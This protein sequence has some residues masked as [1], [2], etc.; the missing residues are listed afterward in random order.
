MQVVLDDQIEDLDLLTARTRAWDLDLRLTQR[1]GFAGRIRQLALPELL[2][3]YARF[4]SKLH[5]SGAT[6]P[7]FRTFGVP[8][9]GCRGF[10]WL[11]YRVD[12][13]CLMRFDADS[14]LACVSDVDFAVYTIS[15]RSDYLDKLAAAFHVPP[16]ATDRGMARIPATQMIEL[17]A[18]ATSATF[19]PSDQLRAT[20][21]HQLAQR[22]MTFCAAGEPVSRPNPRSR[23]RAIRRVVEYLNQHGDTLPDL[24]DLPVLCEIAHVSERTLQYAFR[25]RY[26]VSPNLFVRHWQMN[27]ARKLLKT[28]ARDR[29]TVAA[30]AAKCG[31]HD[32]SVFARQYRFLHG[33]LP[34]ATVANASR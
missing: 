12:E 22:L 10:W 7:G 6:P 20:A 14:E 34:S 19:G 3:S 18:L 23:D 5:Q 8:A 4:C 9:A 25:E 33:E 1:G 32:P 15:L 28:S 17:R 16:F 27:A 31:F 11:G 13:R 26:G 21:A 30:V 29:K 2:I 24:P